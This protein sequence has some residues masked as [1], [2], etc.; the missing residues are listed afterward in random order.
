MEIVQCTIAGVSPLLLNRWTEESEAALGS[1]SRGTHQRNGRLPRDEAQYR[2]YVQPDAPDVYVVPTL[3]LLA[4]FREGGRYH[5][6]GRKQV[7]TRDSSLIYGA[8]QIDPPLVIPLEHAG[9]EV[10]TRSVRIGPTKGAAMRHR[11]RFDEWTLAVTL[12]IDTD[13][14]S[15]PLVRAIIDDA[16]KRVGLGDYRP[17]TNGPFGRYRVDSWAVQA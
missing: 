4:S 9:M 13:I 6:I 17:Q 7:S 10:D 8:V 3:N 12:T 5:K 11:P 16:G 1:G 15:V 14:L 2:A